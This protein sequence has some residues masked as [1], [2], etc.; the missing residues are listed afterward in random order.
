MTGVTVA[1]VFTVS[2][3]SICELAQSVLLH[4]DVEPSEQTHDTDT[5]F[6]VRLVRFAASFRAA[7][8]IP[9]VS[10]AVDAVCAPYCTPAFAAFETS[11][12]A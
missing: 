1:L 7:V 12:A 9:V 6:T 10:V 11:M 4:A 3:S 2:V 8:E 5:D